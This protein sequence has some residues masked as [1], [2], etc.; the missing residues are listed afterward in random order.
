MEEDLFQEKWMKKVRDYSIP[1]E[2]DLDWRNIFHQNDSFFHKAK[3]ASI[4]NGSIYIK[5]RATHELS[6]FAVA[7]N[8]A[9]QS[10]SEKKNKF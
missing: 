5:F 3:Q 10:P 1:N 8:Q 4:E 7:R 9:T 2:S 6:M